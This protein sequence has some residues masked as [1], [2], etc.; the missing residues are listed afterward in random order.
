MVQSV[1]NNLTS[2][3]HQQADTVSIYN[4]FK[5]NA[6]ILNG[7]VTIAITFI[8]FLISLAMVA[9]YYSILENKR[10][11]QFTQHFSILLENGVLL[12]VYTEMVLM[13][14]YKIV[15]PILFICMK[16]SFRNFMFRA[17]KG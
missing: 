6:P 14:I 12:K 16:K 10:L 11:K 9:A 2:Q 7:F 17:I 3:Q 1:N 5:N 15:I 8:V 4:N 13:S